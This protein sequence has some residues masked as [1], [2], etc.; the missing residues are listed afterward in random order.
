MNHHNM[1]PN[2]FDENEKDELKD[3]KLLKNFSVEKSSSNYIV[4]K[5][6]IEKEITEKVVERKRNISENTINRR[7]SSTGSFRKKHYH[8]DN[9]NIIDN[10]TSNLNHLLENTEIICTGSK[11]HCFLVIDSNYEENKLPLKHFW[12]KK[13]EDKI[14]DINSCKKFLNLGNN[15]T[16][17]ETETFDFYEDMTIYN[18]PSYRTKSMDQN[19]AHLIEGKVCKIRETNNRRHTGVIS[20]NGFEFFP[21]DF[22]VDNDLTDIQVYASIRQ[23]ILDGKMNDDLEKYFKMIKYEINNESNSYEKKTK[24]SKYLEKLFKTFSKEDYPLLNKELE[25]IITEKSKKNNDIIEQSDKIVV[26]SEPIK[27]DNYDYITNN[28]NN[29][30]KNK[31]KEMIKN[32]NNSLIDSFVNMKHINDTDINKNQMFEITK[33]APIKEFENNLLKKYGIVEKTLSFSSET[34]QSTSP[35][36]DYRYDFETKNNSCYEIENDLSQNSPFILNESD[37]SDMNSDGEKEIKNLH[38]TKIHS[39]EKLYDRYENNMSHYTSEEIDYNVATKT[40]HKTILEENNTDNGKCIEEE[41][42]S[43]KN[44]NNYKS[45][46]HTNVYSL[47]SHSSSIDYSANIISNIEKDNKLMSNNNNYSN[48]FSNMDTF[49]DNINTTILSDPFISNTSMYNISLIEKNITNKSLENNSLYIYDD[50]ERHNTN[51][52]EKLCFDGEKF[53]NDYNF[54]NENNVISNF[55]TNNKDKQMNVE[56][57]NSKINNSIDNMSSNIINDAINDSI[58]KT[59]DDKLYF[60]DTRKTNETDVSKIE[61]HT[62]VSI[63]EDEYYTTKIEK[64]SMIQDEK[65]IHQENNDKISKIINKQLEKDDIKCNIKSSEE[66]DNLKDNSVYYNKN[67]IYDSGDSSNISNIDHRIKRKRSISCNDSIFHKNIKNSDEF[68]YIDDE[69]F[70]IVEKT[71]V[72]KE[73]FKIKDDSN[74]QIPSKK[75]LKDLDHKK[76]YTSIDDNLKVTSSSKHERSK[77]TNWDFSNS[78]NYSNSDKDISKVRRYRSSSQSNL[79]KENFLTDSLYKKK[80]TINTDCK[81]IYRSSGSLTIVDNHIYKKSSSERIIE[82]KTNKHIF[83][84]DNK[85]EK[86][87][88]YNNN[89]LES[90]ENIELVYQTNNDEYS[91]KNS[92]KTKYPKNVKEHIKNLE[93]YHDSNI[94]NINSEE[95]DEVEELKSFSLTKQHEKG[96]NNLFF[97][98]TKIEKDIYKNID[99]NIN[100]KSDGDFPY[101][102]EKDIPIKSEE[103][104]KMNKYIRGDNCLSKNTNNDK[105]KFEKEDMNETLKNIKQF[106]KPLFSTSKDNKMEDEIIS[107]EVKSVEKDICVLDKPLPVPVTLENWEYDSCFSDDQSSSI[108]NLMKNQNFENISLSNS[109]SPIMFHNNKTLEDNKLVSYGNEEDKLIKI[110]END[111]DNKNNLLEKNF[112]NISQQKM[113]ISGDEKEKLINTEIFILSKSLELEDEKLVLKNDNCDKNLLHFRNNINK[114]DY[115]TLKNNHNTNIVDGSVSDSIET[116]LVDI[117]KKVKEQNGIYKYNDTKRKTH[118]DIEETKNIEDSPIQEINKSVFDNL[119]KTFDISKNHRYLNTRKSINSNDSTSSEDFRNSPIFN[120][121]QKSDKNRFKEYN[122]DKYNNYKVETSSNLSSDFGEPYYHSS[123]KLSTNH[124]KIVFDKPIP[125]FSQ[126][127]YREMTS[128]T[129]DSSP[130]SISSEHCNE[131]INVDEN[132]VLR[133]WNPEKLINQ[134]YKIDYEP[135]KE[136]KRNRFINMEG[137]LEVPNTDTNIIPEL[138]KSWKR[139]YFKTKEGRLTW[140]ATH[141]ADENPEGDILLSGTD[142]ECDKNEG[143]FFIHGGMENAKIKVRVPREPEGLFE[144]WRR[145]LLSHSSS[146]IL[147]AYVQPIAKKIP[148]SSEKIVILDLGSCSIRGGILTKEPS[149]PQSFFPAI[150]VYKNDGSVVVGLEA[151]KPENRHNGVLHQPIPNSDLAIEKYKINKTILKACINKV[152][153]DLKIDPTKYKVLLSLPQNIPPILLGDIL[154]LLLDQ[155]YFNGVSVTRQPSLILYSYDVTTGV[156]V[157]IGERLNI[158]PVIDGYI[159]DNAV[160]NLPYGALQIEDC[161]RV[162]L[163]ET[164][165]GF[166]SFQGPVERMILRYLM[167]QACY[168]SNNYDKEVKNCGENE[169]VEVSLDDFEPTSNMKTKFLINASRFIATEGLFKPSRWGI[170]G[171]GLH[172]L[173]NDAVQLSPIDSRRTLYKN[174]YLSGGT[175]LLPNLAERLENEIMKLVPPTIHIQV[176]TSPWRYH[177]AYLGAQVLASSCT[178]DSNCVSNSQLTEFVN[179]L[180]NSAF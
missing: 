95:K 11:D 33:L 34:T 60:Y 12:I 174:I 118:K 30:D 47:D 88:I 159:V 146:S 48:N 166:Y 36:Q 75:L 105:L 10:N 68:L 115:N 65:K 114:R 171:K 23:H 150:G 102:L 134:L 154:K 16:F 137:H 160:I 2:S 147:D 85:N 69:K 112:T 14:Y 72:I 44:I 145:A 175:S 6:L 119:K 132:S 120:K 4:T 24:Y 86:K 91:F 94:S 25:D 127:L 73:Y 57:T 173:I 53:Y 64:I 144:K 155:G 87:F 128:N 56:C 49:E 104:I 122:K 167:E 136:S 43:N 15:I 74:F 66:R 62:S 3:N 90:F 153:N 148:H 67:T 39:E 80:G 26:S 109:I 52:D 162:K 170:E 179:Q 141:Y 96:N 18:S 32:D 178:F 158:V 97:P 110:P 1:I 79:I 168:V 54:I 58:M 176:H 35:D 31:Y 40:V 156:V 19:L 20:L 106:N 7:F 84:K 55:L 116:S 8:K 161:L 117:V 9:Q 152:I 165:E 101:A 133:N 81:S 77:S 143:I 70:K 28:I 103:I 157:D 180:K 124:S 45:K 121:I 107:K 126:Q 37:L 21:L 92:I 41:N 27:S 13:I 17:T 169:N 135:H 78:K 138:E 99:K 163:N 83:V 42:F 149:L 123:F 76:D 46:T 22:D 50:E 140:Y 139:R 164:N 89:E 172:Q 111:I 151:L 130:S 59:T 142:I 61:C 5:T 71:T 108:H 129:R 93:K 100:D 29:D 63:T 113:P 82:N 125:L 131:L 51:I 98:N 177:A 38:E